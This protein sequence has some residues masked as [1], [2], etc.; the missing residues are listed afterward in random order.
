V[1]GLHLQQEVRPTA[2]L[3][4]G[5]MLLAGATAGVDTLVAVEGRAAAAV[6]GTLHSDPADGTVHSH[7]SQQVELPLFASLEGSHLQ[8]EE[9]RCMQSAAAGC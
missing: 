4:A 8:Q 6:V 1:V 7:Q 5:H 9:Q 2:V 3:V